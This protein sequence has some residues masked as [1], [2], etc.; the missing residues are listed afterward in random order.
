MLAG[1]STFCITKDA[2]LAIPIS[3]YL[4]RAPLLRP[5]APAVC[6]AMGCDHRPAGDPSEIQHVAA[7]IPTYAAQ[8]TLRTV[9]LKDGEPKVTISSFQSERNEQKHNAR[10]FLNEPRV[11]TLLWVKRKVSASDQPSVSNFLMCN[12]FQFRDR[13]TLQ[14]GSKC[15]M[16]ML[17]SMSFQSKCLLLMAFL[18]SRQFQKAKKKKNLPLIKAVFYKGSQ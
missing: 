12:S 9:L 18:T 8:S 7:A 15:K 1:F 2:R 4:H 3:L 6:S 5:A 13:S 17:K 16:L 11:N 10:C 14:L